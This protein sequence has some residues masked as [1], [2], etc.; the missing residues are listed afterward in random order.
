MKRGYDI[1]VNVGDQRSDLTG[2]Y[3]RRGFKLPNPMY[4]IPVA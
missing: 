4:L 3:A 2:G 1:L